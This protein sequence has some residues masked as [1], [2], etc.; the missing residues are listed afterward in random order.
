MSKITINI[1][2]CNSI[3]S[4]EIQIVKGT[5]KEGLIN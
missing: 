5:L 4:A 1:Q 2:N 3:E